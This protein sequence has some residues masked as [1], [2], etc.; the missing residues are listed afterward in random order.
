[1]TNPTP[2]AVSTERLRELATRVRDAYRTYANVDPHLA[3]ELA[4]AALA[5]PVS[6]AEIEAWR[7]GAMSLL[8]YPKWV[9]AGPSEYDKFVV[10]RSEIDEALRL[11]RRARPAPVPSREEVEA[12]M[13]EL[14]ATA[15][16]HA[17]AVAQA[18]ENDGDGADVAEA[19]NARRAVDKARAA[20]LALLAPPASD[21]A[22]RRG[23][24]G[25]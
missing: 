17:E 1:M 9:D 21:A 2:P 18:D 20:L 6:D 14:V 22:D 10:S 8:R 5:A 24:D 19:A 16:W 25:G 7:A 4:E 12:A 15:V 11:M 23:G 3:C 13:N